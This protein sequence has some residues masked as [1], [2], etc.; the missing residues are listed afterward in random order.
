MEGPDSAQEVVRFN[1]HYSSATS[2]D[3]QLTAPSP[4]PPLSTAA[5]KSEYGADD[6]D[7]EDFGGDGGCHAD[8]DDTDESSMPS[9][10]A[11]TKPPLGLGELRELP[12]LVLVA[13]PQQLVTSLLPPPQQQQMWQQQQQQQQQHVLL[14]LPGGIY[15]Q[16]PQAGSTDLPCPCRHNNWDNLRAKNSVVT[17]C[18][19]DCQLKWKQKFPVP[20][21]CPDF[22][23]TTNCCFGPH[24]PYLH[25]HRFK[26]VEKSPNPPLHIIGTERDLLFAHC[27]EEIMT[28]RGPRT[29]P[30]AVY[31]EVVALYMQRKST[32]YVIPAP[33]PAPAPPAT[34]LVA[35][36]SS[37]QQLQAPAHS[38]QPQII[39]VQQ[40]QQ[41]QHASRGPMFIQQG[42]NGQQFLVPAVNQQQQQQQQQ[43]FQPMQ[44]PLSWPQH[45]PQ[46]NHRQNFSREARPQ[47]ALPEY[48]HLHQQH[49]YLQPQQPQQLQGFF[50]QNQQSQNYSPQ[51]FMPPYGPF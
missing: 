16:L 13:H 26:S 14:E 32:G 27:A 45:L 44:Q 15:L 18:C 35:A 33:P 6:T 3:Q 23:N 38:S 28:M 51:Q 7:N 41:Q 5:R 9:T 48:H 8:D 39:F 42:P 4:P 11:A 2:A 22:Y 46:H 10:A 36:S 31:D 43:Y 29:A 20:N 1:D 19:R 40:Q 49:N 12:S 34:I 17:L 21:M 47:P 50:Q 24:C 30:S 37:P 25:V